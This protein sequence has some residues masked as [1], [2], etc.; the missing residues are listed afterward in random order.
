MGREEARPGD[1][2]SA[3]GCCVSG[4][5]S[6][7]RGPRMGDPRLAVGCTGNRPRRPVSPTD[8][9]ARARASS[10]LL[11]LLD[12][13]LRVE[14]GLELVRQVLLGLTPEEHAGVCC[15]TAHALVGE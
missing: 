14:P 8:S 5:N 7:L 12:R 4:R 2:R 3:G 11:Q 13:L 9:D 1:T 15:L 10:G 6:P